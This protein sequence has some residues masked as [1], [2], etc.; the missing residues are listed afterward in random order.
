MATF[1]L[2]LHYSKLKTSLR[3]RFRL[4]RVDCKNSNAQLIE[5]GFGVLEVGGVEALGEPVVDFGE[6]R[7]RLVAMSLLGEQS[8][9]AH[10]CAQLP[11]S[12]LLRTRK[13]DCGAEASLCFARR[14]IIAGQKQLALEAQHFRS[15]HLFSA[16]LDMREGLVEERERLVESAEPLITLRQHR[17]GKLLSR[18]SAE[19]V[20]ARDP[21]LHFGD[22]L[23]QL[24][25]LRYRPAAV[26]HRP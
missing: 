12:R 24:P 11:P 20:K 15:V 21:F 16:A 19:A 4:P 18:H 9:E 22:T 26:V 17:Q 2:S 13:L 5:Q 23:F 7:A 10:R 3:N 1:H 8:R 14:Q 25:E 6:H